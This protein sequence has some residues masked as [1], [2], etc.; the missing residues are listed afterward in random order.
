MS[1][2]RQDIT[3]NILE[4]LEIQ[5]NPE[6][7][8][9]IESVE[10]QV[11]SEPKTQELRK[12]FML[13]EKLDN[14]LAKDLNKKS[15]ELIEK[16]IRVSQ[17]GK[18][19]PYVKREDTGIF[20]I[21]APRHFFREDDFFGLIVS[22]IFTQFHIEVEVYESE[23]SSEQT[24]DTESSFI[25]LLVGID[26]S[27]I[28]NLN[29]NKNSRELGRAVIFSMK[30][31]QYFSAHKAIRALKPN[32]TWFGKERSST[33]ELYDVKEK[34][35]VRNFFE[36]L[37]K[38][39]LVGLSLYRILNWVFLYR[40]HELWEDTIV[41][42]IIERYT[43]SFDELCRS[44]LAPIYGKGRDRNK[45]VGFKGL[46]LPNQ[47]PLL[48]RSEY[49]FYLEIIS[50]AWGNLDEIRKTYVDLILNSPENFDRINRML[51]DVY[52]RRRVLKAK[53]AKIATKRLEAVRSM[54]NNRNIKKKD[55]TAEQLKQL[56]GN[57][58]LWSI[59]RSY[60]ELIILMGDEQTLVARVLH[61]MK[62]KGIDCQ[63]HLV[64]LQKQILAAFLKEGIV[65]TKEVS[66]PINQFGI[67]F[68]NIETINYVLRSLSSVNKTYTVYTRVLKSIVSIEN[69]SAFSKVA[70]NLI[71]LLQ[72]FNKNIE[73]V[74]NSE[75]DIRSFALEAFYNIKHE[76][77]LQL[78]VTIS[79]HTYDLAND[80]WVILQDK[81][82]NLP[83]ATIIALKDLLIRSGDYV[84][85]KCPEITK[86]NV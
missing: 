29:I 22:K 14:D 15:L 21:R 50:D 66:D 41:N 49:D 43:I 83:S 37:Y 18:T 56:L 72:G 85:T 26:D 36:S 9:L 61:L 32:P 80:L 1:Q 46:S 59:E 42:K 20:K 77:P 28:T 68:L 78:L 84:R 2:Q 55:V 44:H 34:F 48:T 86:V 17:T 65:V 6:L 30:I 25:G 8:T 23:L 69:P 62:V 79:R 51:T 33:S 31:K 4:N 81:P 11:Q 38:D 10:M 24:E 82:K 73:I 67:N 7:N 74:L 70:W 58:Q 39:P 40:A 3:L 16:T 71:E 35:F 45:I 12:E 5:D 54:L 76:G 53:Y 19:Y 60:K 57:N 27:G 75:K 13:Y 47:S 63:N 64:Y 52:N